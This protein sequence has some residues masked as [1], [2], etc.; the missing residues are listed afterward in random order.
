MWKVLG[1]I[2][3][4]GQI[5]LTL[6]PR[7]DLQPLAWVWRQPLAILCGGRSARE[8]CAALRR[9]TEGA[10]LQ[11]GVQ[12]P[13]ERVVEGIA[14]GA[15]A[16]AQ[17]LRREARGNRREQKSLRGPPEAASWPEVVAALERAKGEGWSE[18]VNRHGDWGRDAAL[19]LGRRA[20]RLKLAQLG[21]LAGGLDYAVVSKAIARFGQRLCL[22]DA[23]RTR[24][25]A[26][27]NQLSK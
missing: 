17:R 11:G 8:Q 9:Y 13:W 2:L 26:L 12:P 4:F 3:S 27:Q 20:G 21:K 6:G 7:G 23:L 16:F 14:L 18:F 1:H 15:A 25:T 19:W 10:L 24:L 5:G 22:D